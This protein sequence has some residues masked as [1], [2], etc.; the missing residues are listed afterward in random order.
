MIAVTLWQWIMELVI[1]ILIAIL[2]IIQGD[3]R[4]LDHFIALF[5]AFFFFVIEP[6]FY[7]LADIEF[8]KAFDEKGFKKAIMLALK[9][10]Y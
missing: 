7:L 3:N 9:Q 4:T 6:A 8:R 5:C 10:K 1:V 2:K